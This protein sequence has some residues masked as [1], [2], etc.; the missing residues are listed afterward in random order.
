MQKQYM[1]QDALE[2]VLKEQEVE[3]EREFYFSVTFHNQRIS[4][5]HFVD[6]LCLGKV[7]VEC[8]AAR[9]PSRA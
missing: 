5:K 8:K 6:F 2:I 1:Y 7:F 9:R 4:H 3:Y